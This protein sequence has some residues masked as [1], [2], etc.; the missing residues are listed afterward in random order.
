[1]PVH[2]EARALAPLSAPRAR[3]SAIAMPDGR[4]AVVG[5]NTRPA[6]APKGE[7][8]EIE[9][10]SSGVL[11]VIDLHRRITTSWTPL[12]EARESASLATSGGGLV[13]AG[14]FADFA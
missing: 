11:D 5:G 12:A 1:M 13:V 6:S 14:G 9:C 7:V 2:F 4:V 8:C 3:P 10:R